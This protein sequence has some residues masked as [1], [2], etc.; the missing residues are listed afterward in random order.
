MTDLDNNKVNVSLNTLYDPINKKAFHDIVY[1]A[2]EFNHNQIAARVDFVLSEL[3]NY[4]K[5]YS[6]YDKTHAIDDF[7]K[8]YISPVAFTS[9]LTNAALPAASAVID[10]VAKPA[11]AAVT[12]PA[13]LSAVPAA[14]TVTPETAA[15]FKKWLLN[16]I[17]ER[18]AYDGKTVINIDRNNAVLNATCPQ[19]KGTELGESY[20][21]LMGVLNGLGSPLSDKFKIEGV[22]ADGDVSVMNNSHIMINNGKAIN[23]DLFKPKDSNNPIKLSEYVIF[24]Y[25]TIKPPGSNKYQIP[26]TNFKVNGT[27]Y[28]RT[29]I[30]YHVNSSN[31]ANLGEINHYTTL[32]GINDK[33]YYID[34]DKVYKINGNV[35][36]ISIELIS[37][38]LEVDAIASADNVNNTG[39]SESLNMPLDYI[40]TVIEG[41][42]LPELVFYKKS[43]AIPYAA[44]YMEAPTPSTALPPPPP[45]EWNTKVIPLK[46]PGTNSCFINAVIQNFLYDNKLYKELGGK[47]PIAKGGNATRRKSK[48]RKSKRTRKI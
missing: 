38:K 39:I 12:V 6:G 36:N 7:F 41:D 14:T 17:N 19:T 28:H 26:P 25:T 27:T 47:L 44:P 1:N 48:Q 3:T 13:A 37:P 2:N 24:K 5:V 35:S 4:L 31:D 8:T 11:T 20:A 40:K 18:L 34:D 22:F 30:V 45:T 46:N 33:K 32:L 42:Y 15:A 43:G 9:G 23:A 21:F 29:G 16:L 10:T